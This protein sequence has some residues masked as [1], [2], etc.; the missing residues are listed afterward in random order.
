MIGV[1]VIG[2]G[3]WGPNLIRNFST[4]HRSEVRWVVDRDAS[5]LALVNE[6]FP[7]IRTATN[8]DTLWND[9]DLDAVVVATPTTTHA[10]LVERALTRASTSWSRSR[11]RTMSRERL[12]S[13]AALRQGPGLDGRA[14]VPLQRWHS[15]S[16]A[17]HRPWRSRLPVPRLHGAYEPRT[18][19][20]GRRRSLGPRFARHLDRQLLV[21]DRTQVGLGRRGI[22]D[23]RR[24]RRCGLRD[25]AVP[26]QGP[27]EP[28]RV[29]AEPP[30]GPYDHRRR[31]A[32]DAHVRRHGSLRA[33]ARLRQGR[34][35][36]ADD[37][38]WVDSFGS[39]SPAS[40]RET[41]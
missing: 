11:S 10:D 8:P 16:Q 13:R 41:S 14:R 2:V 5:R 6:R 9:P 7:A 35:P 17:H 24:H 33:V 36:A 23:Q 38:G 25:P 3:H 28:A 15:G 22:V 1:G 37:S 20:S 40:A 19:P 12:S 26:E 34:E 21:R 4:G 27:G 39:F 29:M 32:A 18:H 31:G 30:Q